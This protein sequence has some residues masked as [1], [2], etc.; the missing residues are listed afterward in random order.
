MNRHV[1]RVACFLMVDFSLLDLALTR[2][3]CW[4]LDCPLRVSSSA[5][6]RSSTWLHVCPS[7]SSSLSTSTINRQPWVLLA[8]TCHFNVLFKMPGLSPPLWYLG[9]Q[10][11]VHFASRFYFL[12]L[13]EAYNPGCHLS[14]VTCTGHTLSSTQVRVWLKWNKVRMKGAPQVYFMIIIAT[15]TL[16]FNSV[17]FCRPVYI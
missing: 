5:P 10:G 17:H 3:R 16:T 6:L 13:L 4:P 9:R 14:V 7:C 2:D 1:P 12:D 11:I 15:T 8:R